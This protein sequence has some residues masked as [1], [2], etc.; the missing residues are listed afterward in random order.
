MLIINLVKPV[1]KTAQRCGFTGMLL[2]I[3]AVIKMYHTWCA[4][5]PLESLPTYKLCQV[6]ITLRREIISNFN[7]RTQTFFS[8][9]SK[10]IKWVAKNS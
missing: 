10:R 5:G 2:N 7:V 8:I 6:I 3:D 4:H 9:H 1:V